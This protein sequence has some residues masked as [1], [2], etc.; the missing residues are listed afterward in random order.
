MRHP[1]ELALLRKI[2]ELPEVVALVAQTLQPHH[3]AHYAY[4]LCSA[5]SA[6]YD[7]CRILKE[8]DAVLYPRLHLARAA[9]LALVR[10]LA[11]MGMAAPDRM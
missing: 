8:P 6:F 9:Q 2:L 1:A 7:N 3:F 10:V 11:L 5:F 4:A